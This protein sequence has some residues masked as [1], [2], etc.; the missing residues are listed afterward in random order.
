[1]TYDSVAVV[2]CLIGLSS[3]LLSWFALKPN[4]IASGDPY[5]LWDG[6]GG[7]LAAIVLCLW[8]AC[9]VLSLKGRGGLYASFLGIAANLALIISFTMAARAAGTLLEGQA[10]FARVSL[11]AGFWLSLLAAYIVI[12]A[13]RQ[14]LEGRRIL[15]LLITW[16]GLA[17]AVSFLFSGWLNDLSILQEIV[18]KT[19]RFQQWTLNHVILVGGSVAI[20][21]LV[22]IPLGIW[23]ERSGRAEKPIFLFANVSQTI[24]ALALFGFMIAPLSTLADKFPA[25]EELGIRGVGLTPAMIA[26]VIYTLL[27]VVRNAYVA[28]RQVDPAAIDAGLGMGMSRWTVFRRIEVAL[29]APIVLEGVRIAAVQAVGLAT[30]AAL[31]GYQT[32]GTPVFRGMEEGSNDLVVAGAIPIIALALIVD[33]VMRTLARAATPKGIVGGVQ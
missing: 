6:V 3:L 26:L 31:I 11:G 16:S 4:R 18:N 14:R 22:A 1:V 15:R 9:L 10:P 24:P 30:L 2:G 25:L 19:D 5:N 23:A 32:L 27:P 13:S 7:G 20:G 29:A 12:F 28:L 17:V 21:T 8:I 33:A